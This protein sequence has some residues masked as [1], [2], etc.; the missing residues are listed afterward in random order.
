M[1]CVPF[2]SDA[3]HTR[4][5]GLGGGEKGSGGGGVD[6]VRMFGAMLVYEGVYIYIYTHTHTHVRGKKYNCVMFFFCG[7]L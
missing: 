5:E 7:I 3:M 2:K 1:S 6:R 4:D